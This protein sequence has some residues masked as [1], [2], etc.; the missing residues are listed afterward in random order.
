MPIKDTTLSGIDY[1]VAAAKNSGQVLKTG[2]GGIGQL[3]KQRL[4]SKNNISDKSFL[5]RIA[6][7]ATLCLPTPAAAA[8]PQSST[9]Q[10]K[11][12]IFGLWRTQ[13]RDGVIEIYPCSEKICGRFHWLQQETDEEG[14]PSYDDKNPDAAL[15]AR[16]LCGMAFM[17]GFSQ[18]SEE[19]YS[20]GWIYSPRSG[21]T[22]KARLT[23]AG[24]NA[25]LLHGYIFAPF[26]GE[27]QTWERAINPPVCS[28]S[29][30]QSPDSAQNSSLKASQK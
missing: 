6:L 24:P 28:L 7:L 25:L 19:R 2:R 12:G 8:A 27:T 20:G 11:P 4:G 16:P 5:T 30:T 1:K 3:P 21:S 26:L 9:P 22:Y 15:R 10:D 17:G 18:E 23:L 29:K 14:R 13:D